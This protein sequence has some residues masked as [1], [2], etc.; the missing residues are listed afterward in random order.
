LF[1]R[2]VPA[3]P[4]SGDSQP[5]FGTAPAAFRAFM[6]SRMSELYSSFCG[7]RDWV[8]GWMGGWVGGWAVV[9]QGQ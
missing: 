6:A 7:G 3:A 2:V 8:G 5:H 9:Q 1:C 4:D